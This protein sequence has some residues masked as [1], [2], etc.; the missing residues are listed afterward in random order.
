MIGVSDGKGRRRSHLLM[1]ELEPL[2]NGFD[3]GGG[4]VD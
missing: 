2:F 4:I 3:I 1:G